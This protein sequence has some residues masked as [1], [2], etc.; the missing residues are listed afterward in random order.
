MATLKFTIGTKPHAPT[1]G[2]PPKAMPE[3]GTVP[4]RKLPRKR[5]NLVDYGEA[6]GFEGYLGV[7]SASRSEY[8]AVQIYHWL[9]SNY[10]GREPQSYIVGAL[11]AIGGGFRGAAQITDAIVVFIGLMITPRVTMQY[12]LT[13][14]DGPGDFLAGAVLVSWTVFALLLLL[15]R[16]V[17]REQA[18]MGGESYPDEQSRDLPWVLVNDQ[19]PDPKGQRPILSQILFTAYNVGIFALTFVSIHTLIGQTYSANNRAF[20]TLFAIRLIYSVLACIEDITN[21]G[22][23]DGFPRV[24]PRRLMAL[25]ATVVLI[26]V[27]C[28]TAGLIISATPWF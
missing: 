22:S 25:R 27:V 26:F 10:L 8:T 4:I 9:N 20:G 19:T 7:Q 15:S 16:S 28:L 14:F 3:P 2:G 17:G 12:E 18:P 11:R 24:Q 23:K 1:A 21:V 5:N 13:R 6:G